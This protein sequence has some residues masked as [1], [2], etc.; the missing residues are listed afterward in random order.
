MFK[1]VHTLEDLKYVHFVVLI[2][3]DADQ[4]GK[5]YIDFKRMNLTP[6]KQYWALIT[7]VSKTDNIHAKDGF[8]VSFKSDNNHML[9]LWIPCL[10]CENGLTAYT[11][12]TPDEEM[13]LLNYKANK[14]ADI[15]ERTVLKYN[16]HP[17]RSEDESFQTILERNA[18]E[19]YIKELCQEVGLYNPNNHDTLNIEWL[20]WRPRH[21]YRV[22]YSQNGNR[23]SVSFYVTIGG[24]ILDSSETQ[25]DLKNEQT[26]EEET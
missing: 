23:N 24:Q 7:D 1:E 21:Q 8:F 15:L 14:I 18:D 9:N 4:C 6:D 5:Y 3:R 25:E 2:F 20:Q 13:S 16:D 22:Y 12:R 11:F 10:L 17:R 19:K 26:T